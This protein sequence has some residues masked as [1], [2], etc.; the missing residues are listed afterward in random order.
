[1]D[2]DVIVYGNLWILIGFSARRFRYGLRYMGRG[3]FEINVEVE[4]HAIEGYSEKRIFI[5]LYN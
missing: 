1:M 3:G 2:L 4:Q 5:L